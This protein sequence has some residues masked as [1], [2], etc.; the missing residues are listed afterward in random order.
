MGALGD[1][2][3]RRKLLLIGSAAFGFISLLA[4]FATTAPL[5]IVARSVLGIAGATLAPSTLSLISSMFRDEREKSFAISVWVASFSFGAAIGP[6]IG[7][8]LISRFWWGSAFLAPIPVMVMLL[9]VGPKLLPE[10]RNPQPGRIDLASAGLVL[11]TILPIIFAIKHVAE[12][13]EWPLAAVAA[14]IGASC[15]VVF[16][17]RQ[18]TLSDPLLDM[19]LFRQSKVTAAL[20]VNILDYLV[21][22]G[23]LVLIA[24]YLQLVL[25]LTPLEAG[26]WSV[27]PGLGFVVGSL[28]TSLLLERLRPAHALAT[29]LMLSAGGL[30]LMAHAAHAHGL[31]LLTLGDCLFAIG[32]APATAIVAD[33]VVSSASEERAGAASALSETFSELGGA[34]GIALLGSLATWL[35]RSSLGAAM[36]AG[37]P[38]DALDMALRGIGT[39]SEVARRIDGGATLLAAAKDA[40]VSAVGVVFLVGAAITVLTA[41]IAVVTFGRRAGKDASANDAS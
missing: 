5:L 28:S 3:G 17:R 20:L 24:Q 21:G 14:A 33:F 27:P 11:A 1:R 7:G 8:A 29:G 37:V 19:R 32:A 2:I 35:F 9:A 12:G 10:H 6:V 18:F 39:A 4:A 34:M 26:L 41:A 23:I 13:G 15:G 25:D 30:L 40:Y 36:P 38:A 16:V 31:V 22:F